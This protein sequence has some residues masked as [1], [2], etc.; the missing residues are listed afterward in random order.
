MGQRHQ[1]F[2]VARVAMRSIAE[3]RY[4]C[5]GAYHHQWCYGRLPL[6]A[7]RRFLTLIKQ[8][9]NV[10]LVRE[11]LRALQ[12][13]YGE[14]TTE[15]RMPNVPCPYTT[16]LMASA[17]CVDLESPF[18][19][20]GVS[21]RNSVMQAHM[22]STDGDNNDGI[23]VFDITDPADPSYCFVSTF[24][25]ESA[26]EV[27]LSAEQY[28]RAYYPIPEAEQADKEGVKETEEDVQQKIDA[29]RNERVMKLDVLAEAWPEE[30]ESSAPTNLTEDL[31]S[32]SLAS[33]PVPSLVDLSLKPAIEHG[34]Q[35][36]QTE[37]L[38]E[39]VWHPGKADLMKPVLREQKPFPESGMPLLTKVIQHEVGKSLDLSGFSL[40]EDQL[41]SLL[42]FP[43]IENIELLNLSH[44]P[45]VTTDVLRQILPTTPKLRRLI[46]FG[47]SISDEEIYE[48]LE[49]EPKLFL[50]VEEL[51]HPTFLSW[52][53]P[54]NYPNGFAYVGLH[55]TSGLTACS[56]SLAVFTPA[57]VIQS[58]ADLLGP[59][60]TMNQY[61]SFG[62]FGTSLVPQVAFASGVRD[63]GQPWSERRVH[64]FPALSSMPFD[65]QGWLFAAEWPSMYY[66]KSSRYGFVSVVDIHANPPKVKIYDFK[67]FLEEMAAEGRPPASED[68]VKNL[69]K[70]FA[71][72]DAKKSAKLWTEEDFLPFMQQFVMYANRPF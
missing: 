54:A 44:N 26:V 55:S 12:G 30:Y 51:V 8:Q 23:T 11:E 69:E 31:E 33:K 62:L 1:I 34:I 52:Q 64:C 61:E 60:A 35:T 53:D 59:I 49:Q 57:T 17:F 24:G 63:K 71:E 68:A 9:D 19:G 15:P 56:A 67:G 14:G 46:L 29:L 58:L 70:I 45:D 65:G 2:L 22:G 72:L 27:P 32:L 21:F 13:N 3:P 40:S 36:G 7:A 50:S 18:Y 38:E 16:F 25:L 66:N 5:L 47:T 4:R 20:S 48:F 43:G 28:C 42:T 39:L 10:E 6:I 41:V 37:E